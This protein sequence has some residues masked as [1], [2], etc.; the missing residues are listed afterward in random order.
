MRP[1][2]RAREPK[3]GLLIL[4]LSRTFRKVR[5]QRGIGILFVLSLLLVCLVGNSL[6]FY[7]FE[8]SPEEP[9]SWIDSLWFSIVSI[10]TI[11]YGD[12]YPK[13]LGGR[14]TVVLFVVLMGLSVFTV[15]L[16]ML[17]DATTEIAVK[18]RKGMGTVRTADHVI[19]VNYPSEA[20]VLQIIEELQS[21]ALYRHR[22]IVL[23]TDQ[24]EEIPVTHEKL[25]FV[26]GSP[27]EARTFERACARDARLALFLATNYSDPSSDAIVASGISVLNR[28]VEDIHVVA[29]CIEERHRMLYDSVDTDAIV[30][31]LRI[32]SNLL[33]QELGD[34]G[35]TQM[36]DEI[37]SNL[38]GNTLFSTAVDSE[39]GELEYLVLAQKLLEVDINLLC[40]NRGPDSLTSFSGVRARQN[41]RLVYVAAARKTWSELMIAVKA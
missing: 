10:T 18:G 19:I 7:W 21:D 15:F 20:R 8:N 14:L 4:W 28:V 37:T 22:D 25:L 33:V 16:G 23:V 29:E 24:I 26:R 34:P 3:G 38:R 9:R 36:V 35:I 27:L 32:G 41:D 12:L 13:T 40:V 6:G 5:A 1:D 11:G 39:P 30:P 2:S 31:V 17:V